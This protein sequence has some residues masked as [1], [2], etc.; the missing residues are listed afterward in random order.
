MKLELTDVA[1]R[2]VINPD[3]QK[4]ISTSIR[5]GMQSLVSNTDAAI[6]VLCDQP[7]L[8][9][10]ILNRL[11]DTY[12]ATRVPIVTCTYSGTVGVPTLYDRRIFGELLMLGG[13][14]GAKPIIERHASERIEIDFPGGEVDIDHMMDQGKLNE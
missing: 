14:Q 9:T 13:D 10:D 6:I 4:G 7:Q 5:S 12:T 8:S 1:V 2:T 3:W 11:I